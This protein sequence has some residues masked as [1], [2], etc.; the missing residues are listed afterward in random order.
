[1]P[2]ANELIRRDLDITIINESP[3]P[4]ADAA[5]MKEVLQKLE[6]KE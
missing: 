6:K 2:L 3:N 5:M 4:Y 1:M